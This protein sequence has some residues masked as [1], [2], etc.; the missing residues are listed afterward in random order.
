M[1]KVSYRV[2]GENILELEAKG[3]ANGTKVGELDLICA[4]VSTILTGG[5]NAI[6]DDKNYKMTLDEGFAKLIVNNPNEHDNSVV[7]TIICQLKTLETKYSKNISIK[8]E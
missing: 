7:S 1:I 5:F 4:I 6:N 8:K 2:D 3:H